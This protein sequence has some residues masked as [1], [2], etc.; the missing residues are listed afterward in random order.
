MLAT[1]EGTIG[2]GQYS[3][4]SNIGHSTKKEKKEKRKKKPHKN[5]HRNLKR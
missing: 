1:I 2:N 3:D 5:T 4:T